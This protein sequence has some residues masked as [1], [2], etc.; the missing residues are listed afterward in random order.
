MKKLY[1][2]TALVLGAA[3]S[4]EAGCTRCKNQRATIKP[5]PKKKAPAQKAQPVVAAPAAPAKAATT[6][7]IASKMQRKNDA[8]AKFQGEL[9]TCEQAL[10][11]AK[12]PEEKA[13]LRMKIVEL[14][15]AVEELENCLQ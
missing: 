15:Q 13:V 12:T 11:T 3:L 1:I 6:N 7:W 4:V 14:R 10:Q 8:L 9:M 2:I 5:A